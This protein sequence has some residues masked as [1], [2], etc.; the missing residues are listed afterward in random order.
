MK[1]I[2]TAILAVTLAATSFS[3]VTAR[4]PPLPTALP[5]LLLL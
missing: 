2:L 3:V 1:K 5:K 4:F